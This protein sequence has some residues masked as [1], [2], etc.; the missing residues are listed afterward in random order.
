MMVIAGILLL[1]G[2]G[3]IVAEIFIPGFGVCGI[4]GIV[5]LIASSALTIIASPLGII[6]VGVELFIVF[7]IS[8]FLFTYIKSKQLYGK[9]ILNETLNVDKKEFGDLSYFF[10]KIGIAKTSLRPHGVVDFNG[11]SVEVYSD[12]TYISENKEIKV[13]DIRDNKIIVKQTN[14]N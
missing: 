9:I 4:M 8:Y 13:V 11:I 7:I 2:C 1:I 14:S 12:G 5:L 10:G 3:L 6:I